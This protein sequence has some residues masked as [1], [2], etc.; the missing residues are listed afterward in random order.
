[1]IVGLAALRFPAIQQKDSRGPEDKNQ[2]K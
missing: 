1:L 2:Q